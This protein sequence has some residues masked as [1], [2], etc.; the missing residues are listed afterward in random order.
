M[1]SS[2]VIVFS[3]AISSCLLSKYRRTDF[4]YNE[5]AQSYTI[6][7][8]VPKGF[9]KEKTEVDSSGN[10]I[11]SY[12]Y[13]NHA[14]FYVAHVVDTSLQIQSL[15]RAD[16]LPQVYRPTGAVVYKGVDSGHLFWREIRQNNLWVGYRFVPKDWENRFDSAT[17]YALIQSFRKN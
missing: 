13:G 15:V 12:T 7:I 6:P 4:T 8:V 16:N 2:F 3:M 10:T 9:S 17:N 5:G 1:K 14:L 11:L